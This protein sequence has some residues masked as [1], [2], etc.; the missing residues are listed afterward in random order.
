MPAISL[1][2]QN[3]ERRP[4]NCGK[5]KTNHAEQRRPMEEIIDEP[6]QPKTEPERNK[7]AAADQ[8]YPAPGHQRAGGNALLLRGLDRRFVNVGLGQQG[9]GFRV[10]R[11]GQGFD[12][13][14]A[15]RLFGAGLRVGADPERARAGF[16]FKRHE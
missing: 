15:G 14:R 4:G 8:K 5:R 16:G 13:Q 2:R 9:L 1:Q 3:D 10:I 11:I 7:P 12:H 6:R